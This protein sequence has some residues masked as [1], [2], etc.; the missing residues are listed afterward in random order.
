MIN[1]THYS[2]SMQPDELAKIA[3]DFSK[4]LV[5]LFPKSSFVL[6]Y[7]GMSGISSAT[8]LG[9]KLR[10][11]GRLAGM[12]Y[13]RKERES[14][15]GISVEREWWH[16]RYRAIQPI[17]VDDFISS[18]ETFGRVVKKCQYIITM[19]RTPHRMNNF[20]KKKWWCALF[21]PEQIA[22]RSHA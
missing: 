12:M 9:L 11:V 18:G 21:E 3:D 6:C 16:V 1:S 10:E 7:S 19:E 22:E 2:N 13:V 17:F 4:Q 15:H 14:S 20:R 5:H 8:I